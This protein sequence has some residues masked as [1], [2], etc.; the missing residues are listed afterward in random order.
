MIV[1]EIFYSLQGEGFL[2]GIPSVFIRLA[3]CP[4]ACDYCDTVYARSYTDGKNLTNDQIIDRIGDY[5]SHHIVVTGGEPLVDEDMTE[6]KG[7]RQLL[8]S[9]KNL[10]KHITIETAGI[11]FVPD[12]PCDLMSISPKPPAE[13]TLDELRQLIQHYDYQLKFVVANETDLADVKD[14]LE[15]LGPCDRAKMML[16]PKAAARNQYLE[17]APLVAEMCKQTG[18]T[19]SPRLHVLLWDSE[20][21]R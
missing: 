4:L 16:M 11:K 18:F 15:R 14:L 5:P 12:L 10:G 2:A 6:R 7:L 1:N 17:T 21:G 20:R 19:F 9:L 13:N 3:G 8:S